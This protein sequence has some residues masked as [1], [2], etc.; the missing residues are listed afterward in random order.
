MTLG[1]IARGRGR[2][3]K[4]CDAPSG[5]V[6][7]ASAVASKQFSVRVCVAVTVRA[8]QPIFLGRLRYPD[9]EKGRHI[10]HHLP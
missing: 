10:V 5:R 1:T 2:M 6:V 4:P 7:T 3:K 9:A 8:I